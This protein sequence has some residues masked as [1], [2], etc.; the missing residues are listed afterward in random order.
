MYFPTTHWTVLAQ[1]T[2]ADE[3]RGR[4]ALDE[5]CRRYWSPL[6]QFIRTRGYTETEAQD[7]TQGF[8]LH[9]LEHSTLKRADRFQGRF[10]RQ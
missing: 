7:L 9:L 6:H 1:A 3:T 8:L 5:M 2:L 4:S 10:R